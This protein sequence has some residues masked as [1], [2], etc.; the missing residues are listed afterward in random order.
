MGHRL[1][2]ATLIPEVV[3]MIAERHGIAD[4][5]ALARYY[6]SATAASLDDDDTGLYGQS[7]LFIYSLFEQEISA[8]EVS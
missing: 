8:G 2:K 3:R 7:A 5:E 1:I 4:K 6:R